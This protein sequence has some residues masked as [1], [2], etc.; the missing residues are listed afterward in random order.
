MVQ[1]VTDL[2]VHKTITVAAPQQ[3]AFDVFTTGM[4]EWWMRDSHHIGETAPEA[5]VIEPQAGG[6][7]FERAPDGAECDW[8]RVLEWEPPARVLL[9]WH[10]DADWRYD[11]DPAKAT[12]L[13]VQF[14]AEA[15]TRP[16][17]HSSTAV[18]RSTVSGHRPSMTQ[19]TAPRAGTGCSTSTRPRRPTASH[20]L[21]HRPETSGGRP[22]AASGHWTMRK[23]RYLGRVTAAAGRAGRAGRAAAIAAAVAATARRGRGLDRGALGRDCVPVTAEGVDVLAL[24]GAGGLV[25]LEPVQRVLVVRNLER[26]VRPLDR[27]ELGRAGAGAG[28]RLPGRRYGGQFAAQLP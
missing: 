4:S 17:S 2:A 16:A 12:E 18:S 1:G 19:S 26:S 9:A 14:V 3:R 5:V 7:W 27:A 20:D 24:R 23:E 13:E 8:G 21:S 22:A 10:L 15:R 6:R 28:R 11:P 25:E